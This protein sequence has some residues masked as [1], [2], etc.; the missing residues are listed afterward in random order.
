MTDR[1]LGCGFLNSADRVPNRHALEV[2][3]KAWTYAELKAHAASIAATLQESAPDDE[4]RL[5]AVLA[6]RSVTAFSGILAA[7][8]RGHGYVPLNPHFPIQ[9]LVTMLDRSGCVSIVVGNEALSELREILDR[10]TTRF[11]ILLPA[12]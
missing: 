2:E 5:T 1:S 9:R 8:M 3:G 11:R 10:A 6:H 12:V 4:P 7:L